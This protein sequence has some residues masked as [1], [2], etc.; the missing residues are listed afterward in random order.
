MDEYVYISSTCLTQVGD[1]LGR[2][3]CSLSRALAISRCDSLSFLAARFPWPLP[4]F[5]SCL[6][7]LSAWLRLCSAWPAAPLHV[8]TALL[9]GPFLPVLSLLC[10]EGLMCG[11]G[12]GFSPFCWPLSESRSEG[13]GSLF[14]TSIRASVEELSS[15]TEQFSWNVHLPWAALNVQSLLSAAGTICCHLTLSY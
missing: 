14:C 5:P 1:Q 2:V 9:T 6:I 12:P 3:I 8:C 15:A 11:G 4:A 10:F 7:R 13:V